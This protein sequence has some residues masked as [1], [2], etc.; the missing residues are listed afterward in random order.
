MAAMVAETYHVTPYMA[1]QEL[2]D[3]P[4]RTS[5]LCLPLLPYARAKQAFDS[6]KSRKDL[7]A[8]RDS[9]TMRDVEK[10]TFELHKEREAKG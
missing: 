3:D 7:E 5:F 6:A 10:N 4:L 2:D 9:Q 1:A 8:W